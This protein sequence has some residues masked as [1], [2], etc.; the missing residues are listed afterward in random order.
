MNTNLDPRT[1]VV[2]ELLSIPLRTVNNTRKRFRVYGA[3]IN[4][5]IF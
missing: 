1:H 3:L 5:Y 4:N 2:V